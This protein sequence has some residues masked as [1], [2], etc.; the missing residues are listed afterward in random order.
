[1]AQLRALGPH[2][3]ERLCFAQSQSSRVHPRWLT[4]LGASSHWI[5]KKDNLCAKWAINSMEPS[6]RATQ[7]SRCLTKSLRANGCPHNDYFTRDKRQ[8]H[9]RPTL[10]RLPLNP[11]ILAGAAY[12]TGDVFLLEMIMQ[13]YEPKTITQIRPTPASAADPGRVR[14]GGESPSFG[15]VRT[16]PANTIDPGRVR[17]G[18]ESPSFGPVR[19]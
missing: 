2:S 16:A 19:H 6:G 10:R 8:F 5:P 18:G 9:D 11:H 3:I 13:T 1:M 7:F 15:P 12:A 4:P 17:I 14:I